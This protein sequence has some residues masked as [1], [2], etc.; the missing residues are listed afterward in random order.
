VPAWNVG[1]PAAAILVAVLVC[2]VEL[3]S[4][5]AF[6]QDLPPRASWSLE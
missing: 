2:L 3:V 6:A 4:R 1:L 5:R